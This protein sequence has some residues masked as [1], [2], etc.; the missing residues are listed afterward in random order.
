MPAPTRI[1]NF[2]GSTASTLFSFD[3]NRPTSCA[4]VCFLA[5]ASVVT[6]GFEP[7]TCAGGAAALTGHTKLAVLWKRGREVR[8]VTGVPDL[9][10]VWYFAI[11][12]AASWVEAGSACALVGQVM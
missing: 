11:A 7:L 4:P 2:T 12:A 6:A 10:V 8:T 5:P 3:C 9:A 1:V